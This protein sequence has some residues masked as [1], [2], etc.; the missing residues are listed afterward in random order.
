M[1]KRMLMNA[2][3]MNCVSHIQHGLDTTR[4]V[5]REK[6]IA[7]KIPPVYEFLL[8]FSKKIFLTNS[9]KIQIE[10][11]IFLTNFLKIQIETRDIK[12]QNLHQVHSYVI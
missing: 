12:K 5:T 4:L 3:S 1:S 6:K 2:F 10:T 7:V 9:F 8:K 11:R